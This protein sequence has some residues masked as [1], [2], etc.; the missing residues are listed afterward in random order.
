M[1]GKQIYSG[2]QNRSL[3][4]DLRVLLVVSKMVL[5]TLLSEAGAS[6]RCQRE[7]AR[8][9]PNICTMVNRV[10]LFG[11]ANDTESK[12]I[13]FDTCCLN[14]FL[15]WRPKKTVDVSVCL[16][17]LKSIHPHQVTSQ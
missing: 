7:N 12:G 6:A 16:Y 10:V 14:H 15:S 2:I 5:S 9:S 1:S 8:L 11:P 17:T 4:G 3:N 13:V